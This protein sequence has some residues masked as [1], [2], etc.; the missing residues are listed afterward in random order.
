MSS[1]KA[2]T[3][4]LG[5]IPTALGTKKK[6]F[7][8]PDELDMALKLQ[9]VMESKTESQV[10]IEALQNYIKSEYLEKARDKHRIIIS[11]SNEENKEDDENIK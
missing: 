4:L 9:A 3:H 10:L 2:K 11:N 1:K 6:T 5:N 7:I 8:I